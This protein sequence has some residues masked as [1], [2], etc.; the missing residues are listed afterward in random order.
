MDNVVVTG[1]S[2]GIG[3]AIARKLAAAGYDVTAVARRSGEELEAAIASCTAEAKGSLRFAALDLSQIDAIPEFVRQ[4]RR[5]KGPIYGL[6]NN[7]GIG[8]EGLLATM[9][10]S[11][12]EALL[13]LNNAVA[14]R[15]D[16]ICG[17]RHDGGWP[18]THRQPL[19]DHRLDRL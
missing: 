9:P 16:E 10:N 11:Q 1:A 8:T 6:V 17:A 7:A 18:R 12:I 13:R 15:A 3:L 14:D 19:L 4:L 5:D 2:R